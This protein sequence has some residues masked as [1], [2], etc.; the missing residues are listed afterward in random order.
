MLTFNCIDVETANADRA[1]ICQIGIVQ[2][3]DG[4]IRDQWKT[5]LNPK[6]WFDPYNTEIHGI[7]ETTVVGSPTLPEVR[8]ELR[9]RLRGSV[10][11]SHTAFDRVAFERAMERYKLEQLQ[12]T[13]LD[14]AKIV[15]RTWP[16]EYGARGWGLKN[17]AKSL[18]IS[19]THHDALEDARVAAEIVLHA[20]A[21]SELD[22]EGWLQRVKQPISSSTSSSRQSPQREGN[23]EG[24]LYGEIVVFTGALAIPRREAAD[25]AANVGCDVVSN[26]SKKVTILVVGTQD[27][28]KLK[29]YEKS[30]K[31]RKTEALISQGMDIQILSEQDF[32]DI[33]GIDKD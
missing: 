30:N 32:S 3:H 18:G 20:C 5:L 15:R 33:V 7:D 28:N 27:K 10:L 2:V 1:S 23:P 26:V 31:H 25:L 17:V 4:R 24:L 21:A 6:D 16:D 9:D 12:V 14:S 22:I 29:G 13:W 11:V 19:F 8:D